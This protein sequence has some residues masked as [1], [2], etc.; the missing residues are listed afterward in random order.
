[1]SFEDIEAAIKEYASQRQ[2]SG[3]FCQQLAQK[4]G[5]SLVTSINIIDRVK[6]HGDFMEA[7]GRTMCGTGAGES[8][9]RMKNEV[10]S[11]LAGVP[12]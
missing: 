6:R 4:L 12:D 10:S 11:L 2:A 7:C 5:V 9:E 1:M 3:M 8:F